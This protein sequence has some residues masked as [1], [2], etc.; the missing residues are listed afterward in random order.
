[1]RLHA[2]ERP[3]FWQKNLVELLKNYKLNIQNRMISNTE[4]EKIPCLKN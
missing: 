2:T 3:V 1:M 4:L